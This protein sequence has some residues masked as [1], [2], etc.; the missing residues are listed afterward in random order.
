VIY[1]RIVVPNCL[2]DNN[3]NVPTDNWRKVIT[4]KSGLGSIELVTNFE[5]HLMEKGH[6]QFQCESE[7]N[8]FQSRGSSS[9]VIVFHNSL[10][11]ISIVV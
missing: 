1:L 8:V 2:S 3:N 10:P 7:R 5:D 4:E 9:V 11:Q 6:I